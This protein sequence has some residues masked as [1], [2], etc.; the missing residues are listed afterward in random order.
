MNHVL[1]VLKNLRPADVGAVID[2][3]RATNSRPYGAI[4]VVYA[5]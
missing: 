4:S 1:F 2:R 5:F 3:P